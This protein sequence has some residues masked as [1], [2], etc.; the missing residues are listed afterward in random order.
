LVAS[1][2]AVLA[3]GARLAALATG[4]P[5]GAHLGHGVF[6]RRPRRAAATFRR[7]LRPDYRHAFTA[8]LPPARPPPVSERQPHAADRLLPTERSTSTPTNTLR[9]GSNQRLA[10]LPSVASHLS[11]S[12]QQARRIAT[13]PGW[14]PPLRASASRFTPSQG[15]RRLSAPRPPGDVRT[16]HRIYPDLR[17]PRTPRVTDPCPTCLEPAAWRDLAELASGLAP[18]TNRPC[19]PH[20]RA[21]RVRAAV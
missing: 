11:A 21:A 2:L 9:S 4:P 12:H 10:T 17:L 5:F 15:P 1:H 20:L 16:P 14:P 13:H 7:P 6:F 18:G 19:S 8:G 3:R